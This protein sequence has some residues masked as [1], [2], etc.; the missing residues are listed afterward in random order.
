MVKKT[1]V[2][3]RG[4]RA[5]GAGVRSH[6]RAAHVTRAPNRMAGEARKSD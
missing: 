6:A 1:L 4:G 3:K 5:F 2:A